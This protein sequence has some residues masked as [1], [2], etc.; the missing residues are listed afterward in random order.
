M[1]VCSGISQ[2]RKVQSLEETQARS[3][4]IKC[5]GRQCPADE[6][7]PQSARLFTIG[8]PPDSRSLLNTRHLYHAV[9]GLLVISE[10]A[11]GLTTCV[12]QY[13]IIFNYMHRSFLF[14]RMLKIQYRSRA[15]ILLSKSLTYGHDIGK[16]R[17]IVKV[18][19]QSSSSSNACHFFTAEQEVRYLNRPSAP[20][21]VLVLQDPPSTTT[22]VPLMYA[23]ASLHYI[24]LVRNVDLVCSD[25][26]AK[27]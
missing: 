8:C 11:P 21:M 18:S 26:Q 24:G 9:S 10:P 7:Y 25:L 19:R 6:R 4:L 1:D 16:S 23:P 2:H 14:D 13:H 17:I 3:A 20:P 5:L 12:L 27:L 15:R 22:I